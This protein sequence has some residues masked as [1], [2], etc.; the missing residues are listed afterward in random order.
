MKPKV[1]FYTT[2]MGRL[3]HLEQTFLRNISWAMSYGSTE[4]ILLDFNSPDG[5]EEWARRNLKPLIEKRAVTYCKTCRPQHFQM[6]KAKNVAALLTSG[7]IICNLDADNLLGEGFVE[8]IVDLVKCR[9]IVCS[10]RG[11]EG[12][13]GR[14]AM[15]REDFISLGGYDER[16]QGHGHDD[17]DLI[18]RA[19][20]S[21]FTVRVFDRRHYLFISHSHEERAR[22]LPR[23]L[24][25]TWPLHRA[26][27][28]RAIQSGRLVANEGKYWGQEEVIRNFRDYVTVG[29]L[30]PLRSRRGLVITIKGRIVRMPAAS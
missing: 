7:Q 4:F 12:I 27:S 11:L 25:Q 9:T 13:G 18:N 8:H 29:A 16:F 17:D 6:A 19:K 20:A 21:G 23:S 1:S 26:M 2:C 10:E 14:I 30:S 28:Q 15:Q 24:A 3:H 5:L 22:Y